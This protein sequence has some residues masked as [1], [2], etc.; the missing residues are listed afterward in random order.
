M[1]KCDKCGNITILKDKNYDNTFVVYCGNC[2]YKFKKQT[3]HTLSICALG[4]LKDYQVNIEQIVEYEIGK[5]IEVKDIKKN[6]IVSEPIEVNFT[7]NHYE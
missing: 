2:G 3:K 1:K 5:G 4:I 7:F 6:Y